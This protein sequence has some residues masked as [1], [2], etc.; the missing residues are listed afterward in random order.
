LVQTANEFL[1]ITGSTAYGELLVETAGRS[2]YIR[3]YVVARTVPAAT[4]HKLYLNADANA[5]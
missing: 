1:D 4:T 3:Y 5:Q 2:R